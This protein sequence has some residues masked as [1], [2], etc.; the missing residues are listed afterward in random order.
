VDEMG[1]E[2]VALGNKALLPTLVIRHGYKEEK[3]EVKEEVKEEVMESSA[4]ETPRSSG[5]RKNARGKTPDV[6]GSGDSAT[7]VSYKGSMVDIKSIMQRLEKS[8]KTRTQAEDKLRVVSRELGELKGNF[9]S[10]EKEAHKV[11]SELSDLK[12]KLREEK[13]MSDSR[14]SNAKKYRTALESVRQQMFDGANLVQ[15]TLGEEEYLDPQKTK[16]KSEIKTEV[17]GS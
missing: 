10:N 8:E 5:R 15:K 3:D 4:V 11:S 12:K 7:M 1:E 13:K 6:C 2:E 17:N 16:T 9:S 14:D